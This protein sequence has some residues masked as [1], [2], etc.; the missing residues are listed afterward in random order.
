MPLVFGTLAITASSINLSAEKIN[1]ITLS[2]TEAAGEVNE[3]SITYN[4]NIPLLAYHYEPTDTPYKLYVCLKDSN[5]EPSWWNLA[6][7]FDSDDYIAGLQL[8]LIDINGKEVYPNSIGDMRC[9]DE[10]YYEI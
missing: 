9:D 5:A 10:H 7:I 2:K 6:N 3:N 1:K 4:D 8:S